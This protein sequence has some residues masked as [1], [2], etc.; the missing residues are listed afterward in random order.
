MTPSLS[1][2]VNCLDNDWS[3][4]ENMLL[5]YYTDNNCFKNNKY[6][7][8]KAGEVVAVRWVKSKGNNEP[9]KITVTRCKS[10][11]HHPSIGTMKAGVALLCLPSPFYYVCVQYFI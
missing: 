5:N 9:I 4:S 6:S 7:K 3:F 11:I 2:K 10:G 8:Q 1:L